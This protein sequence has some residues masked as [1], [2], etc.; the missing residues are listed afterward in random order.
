MLQHTP[1]FQRIDPTAVEDLKARTPLSEIFGRSGVRLRRTG[2]VQMCLCPFHDEKTPSCKVDDRSG[3]W[4]CFGCGESGDHIDALRLLRGLSFADAVDALG[5]VRD[6]SPEERR[7]LDERRKARDVEIDREASRKRSAA[8]DL[9]E[10]GQPI[11]GT[12]AAAYLK[13]RGIAAVPRNSFDLRFAPII[14]YRGFASP[15]APEAEELGRFPAMLAAIRNT[16]GDLIGCH[17]TYLDP[18]LARKLAPPGDR[19]RNAAKKVL[20]ETRGGMIHLSP[21]SAHLA[22]GEGIETTLSWYALGVGGDDVSIASAVSL[23]NLAGGATGSVEHPRKPD[24]RIPNGDPDPMRPGVVLPPEVE[25]V[26]LLGDGDSD[27]AM[28]RARL[29]VAGRR[30]G[31]QGRRVFVSMAP[32]GADFNDVLLQEA[33][34]AA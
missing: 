3:Q 26:T 30:F 15:D 28:T 11:A 23:G 29:L 5:G 32:G 7:R 25:E 2:G 8:E 1:P 20:G 9:F 12:Q 6:I 34:E 18:A 13:A 19:A 21:P 14:T 16:G 33:G 22:L 4:K 17:R 27:P 31:G 24:K 10:H